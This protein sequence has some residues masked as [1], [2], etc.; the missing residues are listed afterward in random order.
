MPSE[1]HYEMCFA[2]ITINNILTCDAEFNHVT[3][4]SLADFTDFINM[5]VFNY[6][7]MIHSKKN[8]TLM[9]MLTVILF[10]LDAMYKSFSFFSIE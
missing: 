9:M 2:S 1:S 6:T 3:I 5:Y 4:Y 7:L 10:S 8:Y